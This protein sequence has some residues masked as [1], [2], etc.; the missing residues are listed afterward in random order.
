MTLFPMAGKILSHLMP[1]DAPGSNMLTTFM[2]AGFH[3]SLPC[4]SRHSR[5]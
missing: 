1:L 4:G 5:R 3:V 2:V